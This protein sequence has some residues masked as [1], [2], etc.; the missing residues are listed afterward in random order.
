MPAYPRRRV[1]LFL[2]QCRPDP[3]CRS[4]ASP[5]RSAKNAVFA[6]S[7]ISF[8]LER[9]PFDNV[10]V[11]TRAMYAINRDEM[12]ATVLKDLAIPGKSHPGARLSWLQRDDHRR[13]PS[14]TPDKAKKFM[15][16]AGYPNG[17]GFPEVE[18]WYRDEGGYNGAITAP[19]AQYLQAQ[20]K[21]ILGITMNIKVMPGKDWMEGLLERKNNIYPAPYEYDYLDPSNFYGIFFNGGRHN[22]MVPE[23]DAL[24]GAGRSATP[25][26][27]SALKLYDRGRAGADRQRPHSSRWS[28]PVT[29]A[30]VSADT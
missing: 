21:E 3:G 9:P 20:F 2:P 19:M 28:H 22:Y 18:V 25:S 10:N 27:K 7:Y 12:T 15:A 1:R 6:T 17:E 30:V 8:D 13:R 4:S 29:N 5:A 16:D 24:V 26:G 11:R 23:Y 14:S